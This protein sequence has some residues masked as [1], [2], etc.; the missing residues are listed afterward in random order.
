MQDLRRSAGRRGQ[1]RL[2]RILNQPSQRQVTL[3]F[4]TARCQ[5]F[6][7]KNNDSG[8]ETQNHN[9]F[10]V[11]LMLHISQFPSFKCKEKGYCSPLHH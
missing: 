4:Y 8:D 5:A 9:S 2:L 3:Q 7:F 1:V 10:I 11:G 6:T